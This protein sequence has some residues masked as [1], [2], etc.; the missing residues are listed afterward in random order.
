MNSRTSR[1]MLVAA[2]FSSFP[3]PPPPV[4]KLASCINHRSP[5]GVLHLP[6]SR[7]PFSFPFHRSS[8]S[9][10][11]LCFPCPRTLTDLLS[12]L[13]LLSLRSSSLFLILFRIY[14]HGLS[15]PTRI[16]RPCYSYVT[17]LLFSPEKVSLG[18]AFNPRCFTKRDE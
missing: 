8:I 1:F 15:R 7:V 18:N 2:F 9:T 10:V 5:Q 17:F 12:P 13:I 6:S 11:P 4:W 3:P 16:P 14:L